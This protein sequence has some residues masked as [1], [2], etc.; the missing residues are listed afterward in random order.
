MLQW[1]STAYD[2]K[3]HL[4]HFIMALYTVLGKSAD[5]YTSVFALVKLLYDELHS[6]ELYDFYN[7]DL[8]KTP[9]PI[10]IIF[11]ASEQ[12]TSCFAAKYNEFVLSIDVIYLRYN[13][14]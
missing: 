4:L 13:A 1:K 10:I 7:C 14:C 12:S 9:E 6:K 8:S 5:G 3:K 11:F 2:L